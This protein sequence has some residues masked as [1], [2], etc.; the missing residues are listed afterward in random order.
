MQ[1]VNS[2]FSS[3]RHS[4]SSFRY[5]QLQTPKTTIVT[6]ALLMG[7]HVSRCTLSCTLAIVESAAVAVLT[8]PDSV[9][10]IRNKYVQ[11]DVRVHV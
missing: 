5:I 8:T 10:R 7:N 3:A 6:M 1:N 4:N 11:E 2:V 9:S